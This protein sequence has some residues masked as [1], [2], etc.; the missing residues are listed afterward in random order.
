MEELRTALFPAPHPYAEATIGSIADL[1]AAE[2]TDVKAF[3]N[4]YYVPN[5]AILAL[6]GDFDV[7]TVKAQIADTFGRIPR[8]PNAP[9]GGAAASIVPRSTDRVVCRR[10]AGRPAGD[11]ERVALTTRQ[12]LLN[13]KQGA[14]RR[15]DQYRPGGQYRR[16]W[17][18]GRPPVRI[19]P[20]G[21]EAFRPKR[22]RPR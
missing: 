1:D 2:L 19:S 11:G 18:T 13:F 7:E 9:R 14:L 15:T 3:F 20:H 6:S 21:T 12:R 4:A 17:E 5:N 8:G 10:M 22:W 16:A